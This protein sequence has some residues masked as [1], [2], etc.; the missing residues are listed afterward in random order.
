MHECTEERFLK[1]VASHKM[2]IEL[3]QGVHRSIRFAEPG[4]Y[5]MSYRL[6]TYPGGLCFSGDMGTFVFERL[7]DMF[8]F[9]HTRPTEK[10]K[11]P[12]NIGYWM[13]KCEAQDTR[14]DGM[15]E[16]DMN[17]VRERVKEV[18][19]EHFDPEHG[20]LDAPGLDS[21]EAKECWEAIEREV[22]GTDPNPVRV[23]D[24]LNDFE[25]EGFTFQDAWEWHL[26][27]PTFRMIWCLYAIA[28]GIQQYDAAKTPAQATA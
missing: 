21:Q 25:H 23:Y 15:R 17:V 10:A 26:T 14:G 19:E 13:E 9:F 4:T 18:W 24:A 3:D 27:R 2:T 1:D 5:N 28:W 6:T 20:D 7:E 16:F 8:S 22:L 12:I 11:V